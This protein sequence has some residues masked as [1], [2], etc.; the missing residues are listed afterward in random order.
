MPFFGRMY[1]L[2]RYEEDQIVDGYQVAG[3]AD[4]Q[5]FL[6][7]QMQSD[8]E[9][10]EAG[11]SRD[12]VLLKTF[13]DFPIQTSRQEKG[14]RADQLLYDGRWFECKSSRLSENTILKHWTST[15]QLIPVSKN[16]DP[17]EAEA[18]E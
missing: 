7:V 1:I 5:V 15:F 18:S 13:G 9:V 4:R 10:I 14:L 11:G 2:R 6:D 17:T 8:K 3:Y 12:D 16:A